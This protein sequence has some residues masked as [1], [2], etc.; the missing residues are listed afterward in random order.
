M[1]DMYQDDIFT[2]DSPASA[3]QQKQRYSVSKGSGQLYRNMLAERIQ[4]AQQGHARSQSPST[5]ISG[6]MSPFRQGSLYATQPQQLY[7]SQR[8]PKSR[9]NSA[10]QLREQQKASEDAMEIAQHQ[11]RVE[12][13]P[14][15][16]SP[17]DAVYEYRPTPEDAKMPLFPQEQQVPQYHSPYPN[18][19]SLQQAIPSQQSY[20]GISISRESSTNFS[21]SAY[22]YL[23]SQPLNTQGYSFANPLIPPESSMDNTPEQTPDFAAHLQAMGSPGSDAMAAT[24]SIDTLGPADASS[25]TGTYS[26]TYHGCL[27]RF[28]TP[29]KLQKHKREAHRQ[30]TPSG[31]NSVAA[32]ARN[33]QAGPHKCTRINPA[34][35][36]PC[37]SEF[38]R[39]YD[40]TRH[41]DTIHNSRKMKV[42]CAF[43]TEEKMFSRSDAL[44]RHMRVV[45]PD[46]NWPGKTRRKN[47]RD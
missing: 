20:G 24:G 16:I 42:R 35:S 13:V 1:S 30:T 15:T 26:C 32:T 3:P 12:E 27:H 10:S 37:N 9:I 46:I 28:E 36:K 43:C 18:G 41:E 40:L 44:T 33:S 21:T 7:T 47:A 11:R 31:M 6:E 8:S 19:L 5:P 23:P 2:A 17:K 38:S 29:A 34:T 25:D 39:P 4:L 45:H 14:K 22:G